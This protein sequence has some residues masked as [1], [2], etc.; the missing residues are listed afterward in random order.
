MKIV[1]D[2]AYGLFKVS[3]SRFVSMIFPVHSQEQIAARRNEFKKEHDS[4]THICYAYRLANPEAVFSTD[5][6][7]PKGTAGKPLMNLLL[8]HQLV[9]TAIFVARYYGGKKLGVPGLIDAY[10]QAGESA[11]MHAELK[12]FIPVKQ[13]EIRVPFILIN[14]VFI[15]AKR[16]HAEVNIV[17]NGDP[18]L[19]SVTVKKNFFESFSKELRK[20][21]LLHSS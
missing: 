20:Y 4:A 9:N 10:K 15:L 13:I 1:S 5:A 2:A 21:Q 16:H 12:A 3:G 17:A 14:E 7:E 6:G 18:A 8:K 11:L 19:L